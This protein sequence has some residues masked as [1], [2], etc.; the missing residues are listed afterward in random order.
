MVARNRKQ[1]AIYRVEGIRTIRILEKRKVQRRNFNLARVWQQEVA[2]FEASLRR[3][4]AT[5]RV[6]ESA[7]SQL[8]RLGADAAEVIRAARPDAQRWRTAIIWI[9]SVQHAAGLLLGFDTD[10]EVLSPA[11]LRRE[12]AERAG[13]IVALY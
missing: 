1:Y 7:L 11:A 9:E 13:R 12:L 5:I 2:R 6:H 3:A 8:S 10:I 4:R